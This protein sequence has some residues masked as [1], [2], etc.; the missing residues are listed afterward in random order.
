MV[1]LCMGLSLLVMQS[2][3]VDSGVTIQNNLNTDID[4]TIHYSAG[5][6]TFGH[7]VKPWECPFGG[8]ESGTVAAGQKSPLISSGKCCINSVDV[9]T[10][11]GRKV[12]DTDVSSIACV[13][14]MDLVASEKAGKLSLALKGQA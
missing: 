10:K 1:S 5:L 9:S 11:D 4:F 13:G 3:A 7:G 14:G 2:I 8:S 12:S 6:A